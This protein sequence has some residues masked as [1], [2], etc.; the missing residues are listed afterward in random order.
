MFISSPLPRTPLPGPVCLSLVGTGP[1]DAHMAGD[2][3][4]GKGRMSE[5]LGL[6]IPGLVEQMWKVDSQCPCM[7]VCLPGVPLSVFISKGYFRTAEGRQ[8]T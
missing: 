1:W 4:E 7:L 3:N 2:L 6:F 8:V 5:A